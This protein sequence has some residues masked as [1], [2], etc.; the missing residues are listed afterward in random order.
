MKILVTKG[1]KEMGNNKK[2]LLIVLLI[3]LI[4][5]MGVCMYESDK[6]ITKLENKANEL[7]ET[8][9]TLQEANTNISEND[10]KAKLEY[11]EN[12]SESISKELG[13][14]NVLW[15]SATYS[16]DIGVEG[17]S[18]NSKSE[19]YVRLDSKSDLYTKYGKNYNYKVA[20]D[21]VNAYIFPE[22]DGINENIFLLKKDGSVECIYLSYGQENDLKPQKMDNVKDIVDIVPISGGEENGIGGLGVLFVTSDGICVPHFHVSAQITTSNSSTQKETSTNSDNISTN[23]NLNDTKYEISIKDEVQAVIKATKDGKT[24]TQE[25]EMSGVIA[26]I[27]T[28]TLPTIGNV[29]LVA[30]TGG[31]YY[32]VNVFQLVNGKI[33]QLGTIGCGADMVKEATYEVTTKGETTAVITAKRNSENIKK[34]FE[35]DAAIA[36]TEVIDI[37]KCGKVVLVAETGG[38]YYA[39]KVFRLSQDYTNGKTQGII[40]VGTIQYLF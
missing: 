6:Q 4:A 7:Q 22:Q 27:G 39:F 31:E 21:V 20:D 15:A 38:E 36:K 30:D 3:I 25:F 26:E 1:K 16:D 12:F 17:V 33:E 19:A 23:I 40:E 29:A 18:V 28:M 35:M 34:E 11:L 8:I 2:N 37:L 24:V 10:E 13:I 32:G 5:I 9:V 14:D